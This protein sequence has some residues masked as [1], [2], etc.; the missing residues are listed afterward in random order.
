M[1]EYAA[2]LVRTIDADTW[3]LDVDLGLSVWAH[4][5]RIRALGID[6]PEMSTEAGRAAKAWVEAWFTEH[7]PDGTL[8]VRTIKDRADSFGRYLGTLTAPDG[9]C[10]N[11]ELLTAG[12]AVVYAPRQR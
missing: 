9:A 6:A 1:Y 4:G 5:R 10:L 8:T 11:T 7:C 3:V 12:Q 2:R